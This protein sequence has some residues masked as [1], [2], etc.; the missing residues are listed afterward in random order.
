[1]KKFLTY[2]LITMLAQSCYAYSLNGF[3]EQ[4]A[5]KFKDCEP[6]SETRDFHANGTI[7][8][9]KKQ[10]MGWYGDFCGYR[11]TTRVY[12]MT[13]Y[14][15][16]AFSRSQVNTLYNALL[17]Q[18]K[19]FGLDNKTQEIWDKYVLNP[20]NCKLSGD[21]IFKTKTKLDHRYLPDF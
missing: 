12:G 5:R 16:C 14:T 19:V 21:N 3:S 20:Q 8:H 2:I 7:F 10:I 17:L 4:F 1:M 11:Q 13:L 15:A 18:P 9:D 6:F